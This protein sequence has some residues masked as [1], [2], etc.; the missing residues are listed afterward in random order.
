ME[1]LEDIQDQLD[2]TINLINEL[3]IPEEKLAATINAIIDLGH[4]QAANMFEFFGL[5]EEIKFIVREEVGLD[6]QDEFVDDESNGDI[7]PYSQN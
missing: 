5:L 7:P 4:N 6:E 3:E 2:E 1:H